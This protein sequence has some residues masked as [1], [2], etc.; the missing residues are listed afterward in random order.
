ML[1]QARRQG[2]VATRREALALGL[3]DR[4]LADLV[5]RGVLLHPHPGVY[6][7]PGA[8]EDPCVRVRAAMAA[9][10]PGAMASHGTAAWLQGLIERLPTVVHLT[11]VGTERCRLAGV[12]LHR[13]KRPVPAIAYRGIR[14]TPPARTL[15][16]LAPDVA[17]AELARAVDRGLAAGLLRVRDIELELCHTSQGRRGAGLV[18]HCLVGL[19]HIG[20][21]HPSV[22]E[23]AMSRL[24]IRYGL[25][26]P[27]AEVRAGPDGK[28]RVDYAYVKAR[29]LVELY[30][31]RWHHSP[32]QL[33]A[34]LARERTL[35]LEGWR[36]LVFT[37]ADVM[38]DPARVAAD[39]S[40]A[41]SPRS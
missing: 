32:E 30:G 12:C 21:P 27:K 5:C 41:L 13:S 14:C 26:A 36:I 4:H 19:G 39:I 23:S 34:D 20:A 15:V 25:P 35:T 40:A 8:P 3:N 10:V 28:Y 1:T 11:A 29:L 22:L 31:Y 18:R 24:F 9:V 37:W 38:A 17:S 7:V 2:F 6:T 16:D 33:Q